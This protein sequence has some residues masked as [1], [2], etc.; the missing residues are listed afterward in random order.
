MTD[1]IRDEQELYGEPVRP[2]GSP[3][4]HSHRLARLG[5][6]NYEDNER[7]YINKVAC[8]TRYA[9]QHLRYQV[10]AVVFEHWNSER[11]AGAFF[12]G[13]GSRPRASSSRAHLPSP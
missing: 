12:Y 6:E 2:V 13:A 4:P 5:L 10:L 3:P 7:S 9:S 1:D 11:R 8:F